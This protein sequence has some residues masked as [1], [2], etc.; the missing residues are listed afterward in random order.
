MAF[1][2]FKKQGT[3]DL[4]SADKKE[5]SQQQ[6]PV[7]T[8]Q[9]RQD[10]A[11]EKKTTLVSVAAGRTNKAKKKYQIPDH[12]ILLKPVISEKSLRLNTSHN[13]YVFA[14]STGTNKIEIKKAFFNVYGIMPLAVNILRGGGDSVRFGRTRGVGKIWKR[15]IVTIKKGEKI[16]GLA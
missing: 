9:P 4:S 7:S 12:A 16:E 2:L 8:L 10:G 6:V 1:G 13:Q 3:P 14:V 15:A 11:E 5:S